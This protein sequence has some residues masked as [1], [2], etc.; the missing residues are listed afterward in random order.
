MQ[1]FP[2]PIVQTQISE[3]ETESL[4]ANNEAPSLFVDNASIELNIRWNLIYF[5]VIYKPISL[6]IDKNN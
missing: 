6:M 3:E 5:L 1:N 2:K 4:L